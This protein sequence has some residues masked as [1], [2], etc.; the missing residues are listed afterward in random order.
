MCYSKGM[1]K[2]NNLPP[3]GNSDPRDLPHNEPSHENQLP[4]QLITS[5]TELVDRAP[6]I[7]EH[8]EKLSKT[9]PDV[10][11]HL[12]IR[13]KEMIAYSHDSNDIN[14][15]VAR[16]VSNV[17]TFEDGIGR[18]EDISKKSK[19]PY[20][21]LIEQL[22][23]VRDYIN[24]FAQ[25]YTNTDNEAYEAD[26]LTTGDE[27]TTASLHQQAEPDYDNITSEVPDD[28][29]E[30]KL[31]EFLTI[32]DTCCSNAYNDLDEFLARATRHDSVDALGYHTNTLDRLMND[33]KSYA[34]QWHHRRK[35]S[36]RSNEAHAQLLQHK[37]QQALSGM[38]HS[39][40]KIDKISG[41]T[42]H[43][44]DSAKQSI[45]GL[46]D[47]LEK[48]YLLTNSEAATTNTDTA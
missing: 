14:D 43:N 15:L 35:G 5:I 23:T 41:A 36:A 19:D 32:A 34:N 1:R 4:E 30:T 37:M 39:L 48:F 13:V 31:V 17:N 46:G 3:Q 21:E 28:T 45:D 29:D 47:E 27:T 25:E 38:A 33:L 22:Q 40:R 16:V 8:R 2:N 20:V 24:A 6:V 12:K 18:L 42:C 11:N 10:T 7:T 26:P 9:T 44:A